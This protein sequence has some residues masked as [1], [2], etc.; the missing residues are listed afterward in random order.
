[1]ATKRTFGW[2]Q[3]P[4]DISKLKSIVSVF[5]R[6]TKTNEWLITSRLPLL[7]NYKLISKSDFDLFVSELTKD[8]I[9]I[10]YSLL[11]GKGK[12]ATGRKDAICTGIIQAVIDGQQ[13][14][15]YV[16]EIGDSIT[17]KKPYI[18]DWS[19]D[20]FL[21]WAISCGFIDY[22]SSNDTCKIS[23][24]GLKLA[25]SQD[26]SNE[27]KEAFT[28]GLLS[29]P[30]VIRIL[31]LLKEKD[32]QTKFELGS[33]LGFK[34]ELGFTSIPQDIY[35]CDFCEAKTPKEKTDV[36]S[37]EEGDA[38]K[39]ARGISSWCEQM[40]WLTKIPKKV[41]GSYRGKQYSE[42][43]Q[44][45]SLTR[46]G[47]KALITAKGNSSNRRL[48]KIVYFEMLASNKAYGANSLR[49]ERALIIKSIVLTWKSIVQ[50]KDSLKGYNI[51]IDD[52]AITDHIYGLKSI[53]L[54][55]IENNGKYKLLDNIVKL[56]IPNDIT[57][58]KDDI[59]TIVDRVRIKLKNID[60][61][62]LELISLAYSD[63]SSKGK[64]N[65]D[66]RE[67]EI[68]TADLF[69]N[70]LG[71]D[72]MRLGD[73]NRPDVIIFKHNKGTIIDNKSY[74]DGFNI[75]KHSAD[76]MS[77]YINENFKRNE[78]LNPNCWWLNFNSNV[79][80]FTFLFI[81]SY[82]KGEF[83]KQLEYISKANGDIPGAAI[84]IENLLYLSEDI[85]S[86]KLSYNDFYSKFNNDSI[87]SFL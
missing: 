21:R 34:G 39:Y 32:N 12:G 3:N 36:R 1:M 78:T 57:Y 50:I 26:T 71:F 70:E 45:Y 10:S 9:E 11:K 13:N 30:P 62:Y 52:S 72:G 24:L 7:L 35:L 84:D 16:D 44:A 17:I 41:E 20:G 25:N 8:T 61:K 31:T 15:T 55:I 48:E 86:G 60:H 83:K 29:Y 79:N 76:E 14:R 40:G 74:K 65:S 37:N 69:V 33:N 22:N 18:D 73:A 85:K 19:A 64:K 53:G 81:T 77:R 54:E 46:S 6:G 4:G 47:E 67:F 51:D 38:D 75:N 87:S 23:S 58:A 43:I 2:I 66:A 42:T 68:K 82:L 63:A 80:E 5:S 28:L 56:E 27:E 59:N 49:F